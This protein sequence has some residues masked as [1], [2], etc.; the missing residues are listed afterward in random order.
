MINSKK[1]MVIFIG[2]MA[3]S[4]TE[5]L[6][7]PQPLDPYAI[8][9]DKAA[10]ELCR[11]AALKARSGEIMSM[12]VH[13]TANGFHYQYEIDDKDKT[14]IVICDGATQNIIRNELEE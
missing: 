14:W 5:L 6:A 7:E 1:L 4:F 9:H 2:M 13:N 10:T 8:P 11:Q 3:I 12:H